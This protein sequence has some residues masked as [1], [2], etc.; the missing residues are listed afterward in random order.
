MTVYEFENYM[1]KYDDVKYEICPPPLPSREAIN[2]LCEHFLGKD[3][4]IVLPLSGDQ[5]NTE[6]VHAILS[7]YPQMSDK[8][9]NFIRRSK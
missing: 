8:I 2:I 5:A 6:I 7:K 9:K 4:C 1:E 3:W